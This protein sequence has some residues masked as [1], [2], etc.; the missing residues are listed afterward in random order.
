MRSDLV[1]F[2]AALKKRDRE[3]AMSIVRQLPEGKAKTIAENVL[4][5]G[6]SMLT[7]RQNT[8]MSL[9]AAGSLSRARRCWLRA[10]EGRFVLKSKAMVRLCG[11]R[12]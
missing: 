2:L 11:N 4:A 7:L 12:W 8:P 1:P 10:K 6:R 5:R 3:Q 9:G